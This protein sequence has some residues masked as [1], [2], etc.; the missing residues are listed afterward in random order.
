[1]PAAFDVI[2]FDS[3]TLNAAT[4]YQAFFLSG[5]DWSTTAEIVLVPR[6]NTT[7]IVQTSRRN[8]RTL[9][10]LH[11]IRKAGAAISSTTFRTNVLNWF[12]DDGNGVARYLVAY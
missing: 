2:S 3:Q 10:P 1:M 5:A 8:A 7:P 11:I 9:A 4:D 6:R 12:S